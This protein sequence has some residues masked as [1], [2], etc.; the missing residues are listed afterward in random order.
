MAGGGVGLFA[1]L[2]SP[3]R[4]LEISQKEMVTGLGPWGVRT[5]GALQRDEIPTYKIVKTMR[6]RNKVL[7]G[8]SVGM[9]Q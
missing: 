7:G 2:R 6:L 5:V 3:R 4:G 1:L 9:M 8:C